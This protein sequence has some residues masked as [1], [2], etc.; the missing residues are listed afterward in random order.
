ML[1]PYPTLV[2]CRCKIKGV[3]THPL[4]N[5][6][7]N[8]HVPVLVTRDPS[9]FIGVHTL[10]LVV[11]PRITTRFVYLSLY[12]HG[13]ISMTIAVF[14]GVCM[15]GFKSGA[16]DFLI[17]LNFSFPLCLMIFSHSLPS[18]YGLVLWD[19]GSH[20]EPNPFQWL[21]PRFARQIYFNN[22]KTTI[23]SVHIFSY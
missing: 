10:L 8:L 16:N 22:N 6:L 12:L 19:L 13:T 5:T 3:P 1:S 4:C 11:E 17:R 14:D 7:P 21:S 9:S 15:A 18:F 2:R 23:S 20:P